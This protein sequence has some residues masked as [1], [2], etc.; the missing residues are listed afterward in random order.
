MSDERPSTRPVVS[1]R[2]VA[3]L[4]IALFGAG[5]LAGNLGFFSIRH[6]LHSL[7][8]LVLIVIG[9]T[10]VTQSPTRRRRQWGWVWVTIGIW[11]FLDH[12][13]WID[14]DVW[15]VFF[16]AMLLIAGGTLV[17]RAVALPERAPK[18]G[19]PTGD[20]HAEFVRS[21]AILS[22]TELRPVSRPFRGADIGAILGGVK[23]DL[24][25]ARMEGD[26]ATIEI[27]AFCG[28]IEI[29]VPPDWIVTSRV[30]TVMG[31]FIDKRRPTSVVPSKTLIVSG[32]ILMS[33]IEVK[34]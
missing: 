10:M 2:L 21:F 27:F 12:V 34:N 29:Q 24:S 7:W 30:T 6:V 14:L 16:P 23:L 5:L 32:T 17:W 26:V 8:P 3:G 15:D 28:G 31:G 11:L 1:A 19:E 18:N 4:I 25:N 22:G 20:D 13:G 33:G 9:S